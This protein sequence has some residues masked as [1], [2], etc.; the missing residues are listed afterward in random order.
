ME[1]EKM[2]CKCCNQEMKCYD[3]QQVFGLSAFYVCKNDNCPYKIENKE[4][5]LFIPG[6]KAR[7]ERERLARREKRRKERNEMPRM[8]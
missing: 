5:Y 3:R 4:S 8:Q 2:E 7:L 1:I 6:T